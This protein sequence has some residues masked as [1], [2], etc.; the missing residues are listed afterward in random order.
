MPKKGKGKAKE[1]PPGAL[2]EV[3][4]TF[5]DLTITEINK[6]YQRLRI[7]NAEYE[8]KT[9]LIENKIKTLDQER[10]DTIN[11]QKRILND[12]KEEIEE[13]TASLE[14]LEKQHQN[15][16]QSNKEK[17]EKQKEEYKTVHEELSTKIK[18]LNGK[19]SALE[20]FK[21]QR[22]DL[23]VKIEEK[24][25]AMV[26]NEVKHK[27]NMYETAKKFGIGKDKLKKEMEMQ[28]LDIS[29]AFQ[30][31]TQKRIAATTHRTIRENIAINNELDAVL[32]TN[33]RLYSENINM[34][35]ENA[36][37]KTQITLF[38]E[39]KHTAIE[40]ANIQLKLISKLTVV[41]DNIAK[42]LEKYKNNKMEE[43]LVTRDLNNLKIC[44]DKCEQYIRT[45]EQNLHSSKCTRNSVKTELQYTNGK[46]LK[47]LS[48]LND[49]ALTIKSFLKESI[50][51]KQKARRYVQLLNSL[52]L[53]MDSCDEEMPARP[54]LD[55][56][57]SVSSIY[58]KG[59][60]GFD[61][62]LIVPRSI[63]PLRVHKD[64]QMG[65]SFEDLVSKYIPP[66]KKE[67]PITGEKK[68]EI[69]DQEREIEEEKE[70]R[71]DEADSS[72]LFNI[73]EEEEDIVFAKSSELTPLSSSESETLFA[74]SVVFMPEEEEE[75]EEEGGEAVFESDKE[76]DL[77]E[78]DQERNESEEGTDNENAADN[79]TNVDD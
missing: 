18:L 46:Y 3:D 64:V 74:E 60:L 36:K 40:R 32:E 6:R 24:A 38:S 76:S 52:L 43:V 45:L 29:S 61:T 75:E 58:R 59:D 12:K 39:D 67:V 37:L 35:N 53:M 62:R 22:N 16:I 63:F 72:R 77:A 66:V 48:T 70:I 17:I 1:L 26:E 21:T 13:L 44:K 69:E 8:E 68:E 9:K 14:V 73:A 56:V 78:T 55:S 15:E 30:N 20:E 49:C 5:F 33:N 27:R 42:I 31:T 34:K 79:D 50:P 2:T 7:E 25:Q 71:Q 65:P 4:K 10:I 51:K 19:L 23:L 47:F 54:S 57:E 11:S 41:H 28:L